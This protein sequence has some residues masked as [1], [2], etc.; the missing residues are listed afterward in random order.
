MINYHLSLNAFIELSLIHQEIDLLRIENHNQNIQI[1]FLKEKAG[2]QDQPDHHSHQVSTDLSENVKAAMM[3]TSSQRT[4][5]GFHHHRQ[6]RPARLLPLQ[7]LRRKNNTDNKISRF[8]GQPTNC[9]HLSQ[10]GYTLNGFYLVKSANLLDTSGLQLETVFCSFKQPEGRPFNSSALEK[11]IGFF[12]LDDKPWE[13]DDVD[14]ES[15]IS[16]YSSV[17]KNSGYNNSSGRIMFHLQIKNSSNIITQRT[18]DH[19]DFD[20]I[21]SNFENCYDQKKREFLAPIEGRYKFVFEG[22]ILSKNVQ[23][24]TFR[25]VGR[26]RPPVYK[27]GSTLE[28][29]EVSDITNNTVKME[30]T[31]H[32]SKSAKVQLKTNR[33]PDKKTGTYILSADNFTSFK[34][35]LMP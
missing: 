23:H 12:K 33:N 24:I 18:G 35:Y 4:A 2:L 32:L 21:L 7:V 14:E 17:S 5:K 27:H 16:N 6:E 19:L 29:V 8:Y 20:L 31:K 11:R 3:Q 10:L 1:A 25:Y 34:A 15:P 30:T 22:K 28:T 9:S 13:T 26:Y